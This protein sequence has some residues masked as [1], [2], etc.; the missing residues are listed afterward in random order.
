[1][2]LA[3]GETPS[4]L[5]VAGGSIIVIAVAAQGITA[6]RREGRQRSETSG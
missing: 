3:T 5:A 1:V 2:V 4:P 6:A